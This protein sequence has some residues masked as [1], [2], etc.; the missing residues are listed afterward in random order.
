MRCWARLSEA[1]GNDVD[2]VEQTEAASAVRSQ[3]ARAW[4]VGRDDAGEIAGIVKAS[5]VPR[6]I[7]WV[8]S[9]SLDGVPNLAPH[10]Y[11]MV[12]AD[13][14][15]VLGIVSSGRKDTLA[16]IEATG[17]YAINIVGGDLVA[18]MNL[19]SAPYPAEENEFAWAGLR[20][21]P[22]KL[23]GVPLVAAAPVAFEMRLREI[24][25]Y[26]TAAAPSSLI[27]GDVVRVRVHERVLEGH[28]V[29]PGP[30]A[31]VGRMGGSATYARTIERFD[32][33]RPIWNAA[34]GM[35]EQP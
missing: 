29:L 2:R 11:F 19:T 23:I 14:P 26:G 30:L 33:P 15:P 6:P 5:V 22:A 3:P 32:L 12:L 4:L 35:V 20:P 18:A 1:E 13:H 10:S 9:L 24:R 16:N 28:H 8:S 21:E 31:A 34:R 7:A 27:A 25:Q 17:E